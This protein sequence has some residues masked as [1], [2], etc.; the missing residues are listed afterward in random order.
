MEKVTHYIDVKIGVDYE[1]VL[2][3]NVVEGFKMALGANSNEAVA[4]SYAQMLI[5]EIESK[6]I[7]NR[8]D[9]LV[10]LDVYLNPVENNTNT[11]AEEG[12]AHYPTDS[13]SPDLGEYMTELG[14]EL[15]RESTVV[16]KVTPAEV[17]AEEEITDVINEAVE[18]I[19]Q[20]E[21][22]TLADTVEDSIFESDSYGGSDTE[23]YLKDNLFDKYGAFI[24]GRFHTPVKE[25]SKTDFEIGKDTDFVLVYTEMSGDKKYIE[26]NIWKKGE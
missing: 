8:K 6:V 26:K 16:E 14:S 9:H 25:L 1:K 13:N 10:M 12:T 4:Q 24:G 21:L 5:S 20:E 11:D 22:Y 3:P 19:N 17:N 7:T 18:A 23:I 2:D 15:Y